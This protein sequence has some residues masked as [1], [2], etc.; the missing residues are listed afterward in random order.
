M[1]ACQHTP[2]LDA[3][4]RLGD[5]INPDIVVDTRL[6]REPSPAQIANRLPENAGVTTRDKARG[7]RFHLDHYRRGMVECELPIDGGQMCALGRQHLLPFLARLAGGQAILGLLARGIGRFGFTGLNEQMRGAGEHKVPEVVRPPAFQTEHRFLDFEP[8]PGGAAQ[9]RLHIRDQGTG[10]DAAFVGQRNERLGQ[11]ARRLLRRHEC[12]HAELHIQHQGVEA[13]GELLG[14]DGSH[15]ERN[16]GHGRRHVAQGVE[17]FVGGDHARGLAAD[18]A[19]D[20]LHDFG[21]ALGRGQA[22]EAGNGIKLIERAASD[23]EATA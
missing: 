22:L 18:D 11:F 20:G 5:G 7:V 14:E 3:L 9:R 2:G 1:Y 19:A 21:N 6:F 12:R 10:V 16:R 8:I 15:D 23:T 4:T 13:L 17:S